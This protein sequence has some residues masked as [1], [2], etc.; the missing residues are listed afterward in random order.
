M[1]ARHTQDLRPNSQK[2]RAGQADWQAPRVH[3]YAVLW[4]LAKGAASPE[5]AYASFFQHFP[6]W[7]PERAPEYP[8]DSVL[9]TFSK[10]L[11]RGGVTSAG[12]LARAII[13][14]L[15]N[16]LLRQV[17]GRILPV[18]NKNF[19]ERH[20]GVLRTPED[21]RLHRF[22]RRPEIVRY[23]GAQYDPQL[24]NVGILRFGSNIVLILK[25]DTSGAK[26]SHQYANRFSDPTHFE[27]T[28][29]NRMRHTNEAGKSIVE[30][31][32]RGLTIRL[33]VQAGP[34]AEA[35]YV[36]ALRYLSSKDDAPMRVQLALED[37][38]PREGVWLRC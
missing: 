14:R 22:Y 30:H 27:W 2:M 35:C 19:E 26:K 8:A 36:G 18:L 38:A 17:E 5:A 16:E 25:L 11:A 20:G 33:F 24:H 28:S 13:D 21:L 32:A 7:L 9:K 3:G 29:Q 4:G 6:Q 10:K 15:G 31:V 37:P 1:L 34:H 23:F 12:T